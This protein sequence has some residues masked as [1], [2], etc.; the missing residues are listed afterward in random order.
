MSR[1]EWRDVN[2]YEELYQVS[3]RGRV[4][5]VARGHGT[6]PGRIL[7]PGQHRNGYLTVMLY[8]DGKQARVYVHRLVAVAFHGPA[9]EGCE[10]NHRNGDKHDNR[11]ENLEWMTKSENHKHAYR[12]LGQEP[13]SIKGEANG[14]SKLTRREVVEIR[15][16]YATGDYTQ[17]ELGE[18][19]GVSDVCISL[20]VR[21]K[22]WAHVS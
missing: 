15:R 3:D 8:R 10:V 11:T 17:R 13:I 18:M 14:H 9:P 1:E 4:K 5:R 2:G 7:R 16:L 21:R 20:I 22:R 12:V 6:H 19:F